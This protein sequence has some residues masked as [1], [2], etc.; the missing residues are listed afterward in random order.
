MALGEGMGPGQTEASAGGSSEEGKIWVR[1]K[2]DDI[3]Q[4]RPREVKKKKEKEK[5]KKKEEEEEERRRRRR[6]TRRRRRRKKKKE[7]EQEEEERRRR[8]RKEDRRRREEKKKKKKKKK[9]RRRTRRRRKKKKNKKKKKEEEEERKKEEE[10]GE[11]RKKK[12]IGAYLGLALLP[13]LEGWN[14]VAR[15]W[16]TAALTSQI[17]VIS[18]LILPSS[19]DYRHKLP[20][21]QLIFIF[22]VETEFHHVAQTSLKLLDLSNLPALASQSTRITGVSHHACPYGIRT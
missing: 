20:H 11:R 13:R 9:R 18:H 21:T 2:V 8:R 22:F 3:E 16:L 7:E 1:C 6:R 19:R 4:P 12:K 15:S 5:K 14:T 10:E 17:R